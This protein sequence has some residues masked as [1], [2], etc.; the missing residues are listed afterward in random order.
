MRRFFSPPKTLCV[1]FNVQ[2]KC[3][4][5]IDGEEG[6]EP[7]TKKARTTQPAKFATGS[8]LKLDKE[9][10]KALAG[11]KKFSK[12]LCR[13]CKGCGYFFQP[14]GIASNSALWI[15]DNHSLDRLTQ[16]AKAH[17]KQ[18]W[19]QDVRS[20]EE[21]CAKVLRKYAE[22]TGDDGTGSKRKALFSQVV[23]CVP[24]FQ[25]VFSFKAKKTSETLLVALG[26]IVPLPN[27]SDK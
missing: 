27:N 18:N 11:Q 1:S 4:K 12:K 23:A 20:D 19:F 25:W 8:E 22:L 6:C 17:N 13:K 2:K 21:K 7:K 15:K 9:K 5:A 10:D 14:L 3:E 16:M 26:W 24:L